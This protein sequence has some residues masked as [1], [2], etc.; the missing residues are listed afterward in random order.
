SSSNPIN[1]STTS[2]KGSNSS[3]EASSQNWEIRLEI[4]STTSA[5]P[6]ILANFSTMRE[7]TTFAAFTGTV[8][9]RTI[10]ETYR[11]ANLPRDSLVRIR[12]ED[13]SAVKSANAAAK[14][15]VSGEGTKLQS[16][17]FAAISFRPKDSMKEFTTF[18]ICSEGSSVTEAAET[19]AKL[20]CKSF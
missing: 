3:S 18:A 1:A 7:R 5:L 20:Q 15:T 6:A 13:R 10:T 17:P 9:V 11:S 16:S 14:F 8:S 2:A 19:P 4:A 12:P